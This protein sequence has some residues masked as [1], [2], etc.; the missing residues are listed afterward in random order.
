MMGWTC[1]WIIVCAFLREGCK[2]QFRGVSGAFYRGVLD[3]Q[4]QTYR[5]HTGDLFALSKESFRDGCAL[6]L[7][8]GRFNSTANLSGI[9]SRVCWP[10]ILLGLCQVQQ[11]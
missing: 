6:E 2:G 4:I 3:I 9:A 7:L 5:Y 10:K 8:A 11:Y 1:S